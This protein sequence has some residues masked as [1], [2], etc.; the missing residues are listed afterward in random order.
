MKEVLLKAQD[1]AVGDQNVEFRS[2][3]YMAESTSG[4]GQYLTHIDTTTGVALES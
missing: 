1:I 2:N 4:Q 3:L